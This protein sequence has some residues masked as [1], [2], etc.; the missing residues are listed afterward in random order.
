M[1]APGPHTDTDETVAEAIFNLVFDDKEDLELEDVLYGNHIIIPRNSAAVIQAMGKNRALAGVAAPGGRTLN[2]LMVMIDLHWSKVG[3]ESTQRRLCDAR[4]TAL[5]RK[6]HEDTTLGGI[7]IH[8]FV[9]QVDRGE[10]LFNG[11]MF[12]TVRMSYAATT[13]T[14]LS[15]PAAP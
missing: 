1:T 13:K 5:E 6:I 8:G 12:R 14:Y 11:S 10:T 3:D 7:V 9:N 2:T 4:G 15:P